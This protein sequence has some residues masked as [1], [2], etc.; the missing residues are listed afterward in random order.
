MYQILSNGEGGYVSDAH[1]A[2]IM[3]ELLEDASPEQQ[4]EAS[5]SSAMI[6][7]EAYTDVFTSVNV[8][9]DGLQGQKGEQQ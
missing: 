6:T 9:L 8:W 7:A 5:S 3:A 2:K 1:A 4:Y